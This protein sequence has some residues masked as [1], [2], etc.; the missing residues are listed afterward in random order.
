LLRVGSLGARA[1]LSR[2]VGRLGKGDAEAQVARVAAEAFGTMRGLA[3]KLGQMASYVDGVVPEEHRETY[4]RAMRSLRDAAPTMGAEDARRV[5]REDLGRP[6]EELFAEW[7]PEPFASASIG[8]VHLARTQGGDKVAVKVQYPEVARAVAS[9]LS[10]VALFGA[11]L[12]PLGDKFGIGEQLGEARARFLEELDYLHEGRAQQAAAAHFVGDRCI[13][14]PRVY[15]ELSSARVLTSELASGLS[16]DEARG[17]CQ[18]RRRDWAE[19]LWRFVFG[20]L[21]ERGRFNADP[22]PGNYL[23]ADEGRVWFLDFGCTRTLSARRVELVRACHR[24]AYAQDE[25]RFFAAAHQMLEVPVAG[26]QG[27]AI[28]GYLRLC[29]EPLFAPGP[30]RITHAYA[31]RMIDDLRTQAWSMARLP[32]REASPLPPELLFLNRLQLGFYSVL[33]RF[34]VE[35][36]YREI[37]RELL[38]RVDAASQDRG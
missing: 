21:L 24:A 38:A 35:V 23:F 28:R 32:R 6:P 26:E 29:F 13:R 15:P 37:H 18:G 1:G 8:Q 36:D 11:L 19:T 20:S 25:P 30:Y 7:S 22:H 16:F 31:R 5:I 12:G 27:K 14:I 3:L 33:A 9:D 17:L 2:V 4:E 10:N 34:D